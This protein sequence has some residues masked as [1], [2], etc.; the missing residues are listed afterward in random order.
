[1]RQARVVGVPV[2]VDGRERA[3]WPSD[4]ATT[5]LRR[6]TWRI[7]GWRARGEMVD[8][9]ANAPAHGN[10]LPPEGAM[11]PA[12]RDRRTASL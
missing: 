4:T 11:S 2:P 1:M 9:V 12:R 7:V 6:H 3:A 10:P 5:E 8:S